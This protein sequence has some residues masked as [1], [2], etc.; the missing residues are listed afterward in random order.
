MEGLDCD[1]SDTTFCLLLFD[2]KLMMELPTNK[3]CKD[4]L[5]VR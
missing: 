1:C 3:H 5:F 2:L 4:V